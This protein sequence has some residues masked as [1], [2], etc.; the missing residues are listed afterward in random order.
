MRNNIGRRIWDSFRRTP[1]SFICFLNIVPRLKT[2]LSEFDVFSFIIDMDCYS[3]LRDI[4]RSTRPNMQADKLNTLR[5]H[6]LLFHFCRNL[7]ILRWK[8]LDSV[9]N[10]LCCALYSLL[11]PYWKICDLTDFQIE[12]FLRRRY[13][14]SISNRTARFTSLPGS[15]QKSSSLTIRYAPRTRE[16]TVSRNLLLTRELVAQSLSIPRIKLISTFTFSTNFPITIRVFQWPMARDKD[17]I[18]CLATSEANFSKRFTF[19]RSNA[20]H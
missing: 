5:K 12:S 4:V 7:P 16:N 1:P 10:D 20:R 14:L 17:T 6:V 11:L 8:I 3:V 13:L 19:I 15:A 9:L 2:R 18:R